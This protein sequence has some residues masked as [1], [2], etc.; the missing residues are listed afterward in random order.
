MRRYAIS[1]C[2]SVSL[3]AGCATAPTAQPMPQRVQLPALDQVAPDVL[4]P[5]FTDRMES[6]LSGKLPE[7]T[8]CASP[9]EPAKPNTKKPASP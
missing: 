1:M 3:L 4:E 2:A 7:P 5:S 9:C 6:F 8:P